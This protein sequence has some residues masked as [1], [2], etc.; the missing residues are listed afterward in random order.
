MDTLE[1]LKAF[2][3]GE[4]PDQATT[5]QLAAE[6]YVNVAEVTNNDTPVGQREF[7]ITSITEKGKRVLE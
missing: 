2:Q 6:G 5:K 4:R 3:R 1:A 7:L